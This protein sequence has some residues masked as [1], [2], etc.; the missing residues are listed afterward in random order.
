MCAHRSVKNHPSSLVLQENLSDPDANLLRASDMY[1]A[2]KVW[3]ALCKKEVQLVPFHR[4][5][6]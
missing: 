2:N 5:G 1:F 6:W 4:C 3:L